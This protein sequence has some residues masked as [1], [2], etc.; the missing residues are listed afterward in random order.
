MVVLGKL[1]FG[2]SD[3]KSKDDSALPIHSSSLM[4]DAGPHQPGEANVAR[5]LTSAFDDAAERVPAPKL[6]SSILDRRNDSIHLNS[7]IRQPPSLVED[8]AGKTATQR[9]L[10]QDRA[11]I[12][13]AGAEAWI[14]QVLELLIL[15]HRCNQS[16]QGRG[17]TDS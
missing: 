2:T 11:P 4:L 1:E 3:R 10:G 7:S 12:V 15:L 6:E 16:D 17:L 14:G 9:R 8:Q 13:E 5:Q